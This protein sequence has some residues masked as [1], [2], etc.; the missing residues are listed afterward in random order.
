MN[1]IYLLIL[2]FFSLLDLLS[3]QEAGL[4][5]LPVAY[6]G[7][8]REFSAY[9]NL[10]LY[11][12]YHAINLKKNDLPQQGIKNTEDLLLKVHFTGHQFLDQYNFFWLQ[13][14]HLKKILDLDLKSNRFSYI[15]LQNALWRQTTENIQEFAPIKSLISVYESYRGN[16]LLLEEASQKSIEEWKSQGISNKQIKHLY[17]ERFPLKKKLLQAGSTLKMLPGKRDKGEW[18]SLHAL[19]VMTYDPILGRPTRVKNFTLYPDPLFEKIQTTYLRLQN[20]YLN[21]ETEQSISLLNELGD[22]LKQGYHSI[23]GSLINP[24]VHS[25]LLY[26]TFNQLHAESIYYSAPLIEIALAL[27]GVAICIFALAFAIKSRK[28]ETLAALVVAAAFIVHT[29]I[30]C[31]RCY[32]LNRAPVSN[33]FE[34]VVYVP[35]ISVL[36]GF[37]LKFFL[38]NTTPLFASSFIAL[39][40]LVLLKISNVNS[41]MENVQAVL[42]SQYWL[43]IHVMMI[44]GSYGIFALSGI[45]SHLYLIG[46]VIVRNESPLLKSMAASILQTLYIGI[47]LLI[48][49]T[50]LGGVWA[51]QS[52]GRFWDWDPKESWAFISSCVYLICIHAYRFGYIKHT[53]LAIGS[54]IGLISIS[55][56]WYGVNYILG[57]GLHSYGFGSGGNS[58]YY[59]YLIAECIFLIATGLLSK[60]YL[61]NKRKMSYY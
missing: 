11:D 26:P 48:P 15:H 41:R 30:I 43:I 34:T 44:V 17:E 55:F 42:D 32:I 59:A 52:W 40:L 21:D 46:M 58:Y 23:E 5:G 31:L 27:Y 56:T 1:R 51:A 22:L 36:F 53:G 49:G 24:E 2:T 25:G 20:A 3:A 4:S 28:T 45:L 7:R 9:T 39:S 10:W 12:F 14:A 13:D 19:Q 38:K 47:L 33:M 8:Y 35:W 16:T 57:T 29:V 18:Y 37:L 54:I 60:I 61:L 50:I 6:Q